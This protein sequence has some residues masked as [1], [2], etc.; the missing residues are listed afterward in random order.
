MNRGEI[1]TVSGSGYAGK[2][3]PAVIVQ[4]NRFDVTASVTICV[5]TTDDT[6]AP[7]F[8]ISV[9]PSESNGLRS[10]SRL[11]VDKLT[12]VSRERLGE[13]IG[14]LDDADVVRMD[15]AIMVFLGLA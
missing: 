13:R 11:M 8:R 3:R 9:T 14:C 7:L 1:W 2:P 5:F 6:D 12:T 15:R 10:A 4:D